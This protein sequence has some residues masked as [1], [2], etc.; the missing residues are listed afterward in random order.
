MKI[1]FVTRG[2]PSKGKPMDGNYEAIQAK[3]IDKR[4]HDVINISIK[5]KSLIHFFTNRKIKQRKDEGVFVYEYTGILPVIPFLF[6]SNC[7]LVLWV[8]KRILCK[9]YSSIVLN[10]GIPDL[11][12]SHSL[13][14]SEYAIV[15]KEK[16]SIPIVFTEHWSQLNSSKINKSLYRKG[17][18]YQKA[19]AIIAVSNSFSANIQNHFKIKSHVIHNM[20][21]EKF[22]KMCKNSL[23]NNKYA[24]VSVGSLI[25]GKGFDILIHA[26]KRAQFGA[27]VFL[28]IIGDGIE[29]EKLQKTIIDLNLQNQ[30]FLLGLKSSLEVNEIMANSDS[31]VLASRRET[32]GIVYIEAMAKG[33]PVVA[34]RCGGPEEFINSENGILV[35][36]DNV[37]ELTTALMF[38]YEQK[39]NYNRDL[40]RKYCY[41]NFS[42]KVISSQILEIYDLVIKKDKK[43]K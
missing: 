34:T 28:N 30:V 32:F 11:V 8:K 27:N 2:Y 3:A 18:A 12:H 41:D 7:S 42:E 35:N 16:F 21:E 20:V 33:L 14:I 23:R 36:V 13:F 43:I 17:V 6:S 39:E 31:F 26:F 25:S 37:E 9:V 5:W 15:L 38:I 22:F 1:L 19:D 4:G 10:H 24:F 29:R 40:I